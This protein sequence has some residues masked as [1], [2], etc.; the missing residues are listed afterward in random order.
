MT[1]E[2]RSHKQFVKFTRRAYPGRAVQ[3]CRIGL[4]GCTQNTPGFARNM[5]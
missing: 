2:L 4:A 3:L 5:R 1:T